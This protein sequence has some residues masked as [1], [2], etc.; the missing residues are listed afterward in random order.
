MPRPPNPDERRR[1]HRHRIHGPADFR[2]QNWYLRS[3]RILNLCLDGCLLEPRLATDC[4]P[5]DLLDLRFE[6][7]GLAFRARS[8]V[9]RVSPDG[10][11]GIELIQLSDRSRNQLQ[12][13]IEELEPA[14]DKL[15]P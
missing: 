15:N 2:I 12:L 10:L 5:G 3:G 13:L 14:G 6:I 11:L 7:H 8:V 4:V 1:A 9:R